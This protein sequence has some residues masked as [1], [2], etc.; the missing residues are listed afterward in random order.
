MRLRTPSSERWH[1]IRQQTPST[2][3]DNN[4]HWRRDMRLRFIAL[5]AS[6]ALVPAAALAQ[7]GTPATTPNAQSQ[8][9]PGSQTPS[10]AEFVDKAASSNLFEIQ[11]SQ[12][13][14]EKAQQ[15]QVRQFAQRM[16][17]DHTAA[18]D[19]LKAAAQG[20]TVPTPLD[21]Q[22]TQMLQTL[23]GASGAGF[24]RNYAQMQVTAHR[25]AVSLFDRYAQSGDDQQLKQFASQTLPTL[26]EH[27]QSIEQIQRSLPPAQ[28]G[29][30]QGAGN[31]QSAQNQAGQDPSRIV[32]Q[33]PAPTIRVDQASPQV[34]VQQPQPRVTV[35]QAQP[36]ILVRQPQP[37]VTVDIPQPE[38][39]VRMPQPDVN[40]AMAQPQVQVNQP[41]PQVQVVQPQ[42]KPEVNVERA[43]PQVMVQQSGREPNVDVQRTEGQPTVR[44]ERAEPR[45]VVNQAQGQPT[46]RVERMGEG[47]QPGPE[48][49]AAAQQPAADR[50]GEARQDAQTRTTTAASAQRP[51][52]TTG[53]ISPGAQQVAVSRITD[54][55][56]YNTRNEQLGDV[57]RV[58]QG[59]DGKTYIVIGHGGFLGLGEKKV[60]VP[61]ERVAMRGDRLIIQGMTDD[62]IKAMPAWNADARDTREFGRTQQVPL[63]AMQ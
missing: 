49:Q 18:G 29:E 21:Q 58:I 42:R 25:E 13:A 16:V 30:A 55:N 32:V 45:V 41:Q 51:G 26:R 23:R 60:A 4:F 62:Q 24:D 40:V 54:M 44:Y 17:Q 33:Q 9:Q 7:T 39:I 59:H 3:S 27:L 37:T 20:Q 31:Q 36:E 5:A 14:L 57:E 43:Q 50:Q 63:A 53:A 48:R 11:S 19:K 6:T 28:V 34:T 56:L 46:V 2:H 47:E 10:K 52:E 22:H 61:L 38:I 1:V 12:L 15:N 35:R 8:P